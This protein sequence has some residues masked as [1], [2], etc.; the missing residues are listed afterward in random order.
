MCPP[1]SPTRITNTSILKLAGAFHGRKTS[2]IRFCAFSYSAGEPC[3]RSN[4]LI[5]YFIRILL[6]RV[7]IVRTRLPPSGLSDIHTR[8]SL[9]GVE[10]NL[11]ELPR[12]QAASFW[13]SA[14]RLRAS[15]A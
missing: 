8:E 10:H 15:A 11:A 9:P 4:Q 14:S 1:H 5:M 2:R 12:N 13:L 7:E 6:G 3:E